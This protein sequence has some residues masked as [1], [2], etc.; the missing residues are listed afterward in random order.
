MRDREDHSEIKLEDLLQLKRYE[1]PST[2][3]WVG[4]EERIRHKAMQ[5]IV[6]RKRKR[7]KLFAFLKVTTPHVPVAAAIVFALTIFV[8]SE[9]LQNDSVETVASSHELISVE[10]SSSEISDQIEP[11]FIVDFIPVKEEDDLS[12]SKDFSPEVYILAS[13]ENEYTEYE[14]S[15]IDINVSSL[16]VY[17]SAF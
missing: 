9:P 5:E 6:Q 17:A 14:S 2:S 7:D 10:Q 12:Y 16:G 1:K 15:S 11:S 13:A 8:P 4:F 3:V